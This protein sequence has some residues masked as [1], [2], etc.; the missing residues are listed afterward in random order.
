MKKGIGGW[1]AAFFFSIQTIAKM[2]SGKRFP[3]LWA[4]LEDGKAQ[5]LHERYLCR[6]RA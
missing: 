5:T 1:N 6:H 3:T 2:K 4:F